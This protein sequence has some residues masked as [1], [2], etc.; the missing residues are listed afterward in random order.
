M[1]VQFLE[2]NGSCVRAQETAGGDFSFSLPEQPSGLRN[3]RGLAAFAK[4]L[5]IPVVLD[6]PDAP[7]SVGTSH[8]S[9]RP[10]AFMFGGFCYLGLHPLKSCFAPSREPA[11]C[12]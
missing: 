10:A 9:S 2:A 7:S 4:G 8:N 11:R 1:V 12:G 3:V 6:P 5:A